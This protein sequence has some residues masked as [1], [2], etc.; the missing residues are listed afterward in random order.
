MAK[1]RRGFRDSQ[2]LKMRKGRLAET[3]EEEERNRPRVSSLRLFTAKGL[4]KHHSPETRWF[5]PAPWVLPHAGGRSICPSAQRSCGHQ[6]E[7]A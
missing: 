7:A 5:P 1:V 4:R 6:P 2:A 3:E